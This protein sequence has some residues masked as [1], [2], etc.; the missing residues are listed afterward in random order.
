M[1]KRQTSERKPTPEVTPPAARPGFFEQVVGE[2]KAVSPAL[3]FVPLGLSVWL[4]W[5]AFKHIKKNG[6]D[7]AGWDPS[8][9]S[10]LAWL[11][12]FSLLVLF[13]AGLKR[14]LPGTLTM[15]GI[16]GVLMFAM[17]VASF[18]NAWATERQN[19]WDAY[20]FAALFW[21]AAGSALTAV[22]ALTI[23]ARRGS[24]TCKGLQGPAGVC[25]LI[26][27]VAWLWTWN[28]W[29]QALEGWIARALFLATH[30]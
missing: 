18:G 12:L 19:Y 13:I 11:A 9:F 29:L 14:E 5:G 20:H 1:S 3:V 28:P 17:A 21:M 23:G 6:A 10:S 30:R 27:F 15:V 4:L 7:A 2:F 16:G 22:V 25:L 8:D 24:A 26:C